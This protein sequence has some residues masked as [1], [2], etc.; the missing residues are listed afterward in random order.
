MTETG[1]MPATEL[2]DEALRA[3]K[4]AQ[5][6]EPGELPGAAS[7]VLQHASRPSASPH[8]IQIV[9]PLL[10]KTIERH[11][12]GSVSAASHTGL[13]VWA[14]RTPTQLDPHSAYPM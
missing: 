9:L 14:S 5:R 12:E 13:R 11:S 2:M 4:L 3:F 7:E 10:K 6:L 8:S 1:E